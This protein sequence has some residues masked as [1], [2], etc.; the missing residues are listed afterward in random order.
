MLKIQTVLF[1]FISICFFSCIGRQAYYVSPFN[2]ITNPYH[3]IP[4]HKDSLKSASYLNSVIS[5]GGANEGLTDPVYSFTENVSRSHN[6]GMFQAYYGAG[7]TVGSYKIKPYDS[8]GNNSTVNYIIINQNKGNYFFGGGGFD[9]GID[10]VT[11]SE[12]FEWRALGAE[13]SLRQEFGNYVHAR[14]K[15][16]DSAATVVIRNRFFGTVGLFTE[17]VGRGRNTETGCK[18]GWGT[19]IGSDYHNFQFTDSYFADNPPRFGYFTLNVHT[20]A[21]KWTGYIQGNFAKKASAF[22]IGMNYRI[23]K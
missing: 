23:S 19:V 11:G 16:P 17:V 10:F 15:I 5:I 1:S 7:L 22:L 9:G 6:F 2:G 12:K 14:N 21:N 18:L 20:T 8:L 4:M 3:T 13:I